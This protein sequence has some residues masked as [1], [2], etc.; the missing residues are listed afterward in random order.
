MNSELLCYVIS[1][2]PVLSNKTIVL[3]QFEVCNYRR[4]YFIIIIVKILLSNFKIS[5]RKQ[6]LMTLLSL[7]TYTLHLI[8]FY[9]FN[10]YFF[11]EEE[12]EGAVFDVFTSPSNS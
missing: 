7:A 1:V 9:L 3:F 4:T 2:N 12:E 5:V 6:Y 11:F 8:I 10:L